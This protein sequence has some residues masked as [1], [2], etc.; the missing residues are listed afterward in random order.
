MTAWRLCCAAIL[1]IALS[2]T[3]GLAAARR[4]P[5]FGQ[6]LALGDFTIP[7]GWAGIWSSSDTI[8]VCQ[9]PT[10]E[11]IETNVD[12]LC[13][14]EAIAPGV[15]YSCTGTLTDT[16]ANTVCSGSFSLEGGRADYT[17]TLQATRNGDSA[18][19]RTTSGVVYTPPLCPAGGLVRGRFAE[20]DANRAASPLVRDP[21]VEH[22][23]GEAQ[24]AVPVTRS[25]REPTPAAIA[26][27]SRAPD[28]RC[29]GLT[30]IG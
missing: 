14:G 26:P 7:S 25:R 10:I 22:H 12:T 3:E 29:C 4:V 1:A 21:D 30:G 28:P 20:H 24:A 13:A 23:L 11:D 5:S 2:P 19:A 8:R 6:A 17:F 18:Y 27:V 15:D 16:E 9:N